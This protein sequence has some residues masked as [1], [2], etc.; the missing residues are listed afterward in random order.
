MNRK[1]LNRKITER[2]HE[3]LALIE[4]SGSSIPIDTGALCNTA[5]V[6]IFL[7]YY[8]LIYPG[9]NAKKMADEAVERLFSQCVE[10][11]DL[12]T[13]TISFCSGIL[14]TGW[15]SCF[16]NQ[17]N[18]NEFDDD[19]ADLDA[20]A[21][22]FFF[23]SIAKGNYDFLHGA[24]GALFYMV[25]RERNKQ[26]TSVVR[27]MISSLIGIA[28]RPDNLLYWHNYDATTHESK[29]QTINLGLSHGTPSILAILTRAFKFLGGGKQL[30]LE[31]EKCAHSIIF[32]KNGE[33]S[34]FQYP[35]TKDMTDLRDG[36]SRLGW[37]YGDIGVAI[38]LWNAGITL[39]KKEFL[40]EAIGTLV[41]ASKVRNTIDGCV[42]DA[43]ICHGAAGVSHIFYRFYERTKEDVFL[44]ASDFW[45]EMA[46]DFL[47]PFDGIMTAKTSWHAQHG[48]VNKFGLLEGISGVGLGL[49]SRISE[50]HLNW[51]SC[52]LI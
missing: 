32:C 28:Q 50:K 7:Y 17:N 24:S 1:L 27:R 12:D 9:T 47:E 8:D 29:N 31:I 26:R 16:L 43:A 22:S 48:Y 10:I 21:E 34:I 15:L 14:G 20:L 23:E 19:L 4:H 36:D 46:V 35:Y 49:M 5:G 25:N 42:N 11:S 30:A 45:A 6:T 52:L 18:F 37:C 38:S 40:D 41:S 33:D 39:N 13:G 51:D 2:I 3:I 44:D